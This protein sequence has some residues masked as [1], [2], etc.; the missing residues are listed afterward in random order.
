[1]KT[2]PA[3]KPPAVASAIEA[4]DDFRKSLA[5]ASKLVV[6]EGLPHQLFEQAVM[7]RESERPDVTRIAGYPF[8]TPAVSAKNEELLEKLLSDPKSIDVWIGEKWCGGFHPDYSVSWTSGGNT[9]S[10]LIC[11]GCEEVIFSEG[12]R[13][14]RYELAHEACDA[15]ER[16]LASY[17]SKRPE[18]KFD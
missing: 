15:F 4:T 7:Q 11:F 10:A 2:F 16:D 18:R 9:Y 6:Y 8:Y 5:T 13:R 1:M 12:T 3:A 14:F 17:R